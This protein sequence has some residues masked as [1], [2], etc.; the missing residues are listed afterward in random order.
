MAHK[1]HLALAFAGVAA[2]VLQGCGWHEPD[3]PCQFV[4]LGRY[5][6]D[7]RSELRIANDDLSDADAACCNSVREYF[8]QQQDGGPPPEHSIVESCGEAAD[9]LPSIQAM[10]EYIDPDNRTVEDCMVPVGWLGAECSSGQWSRG[11][12]LGQK[13]HFSHW[14]SM[15]SEPSDDIGEL[16]W[17]CLDDEAPASWS[18]LF[19]NAS[20][21]LGTLVETV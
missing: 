2:V 8:L 12:C 5:S 4:L 17:A 13:H 20:C 3:H 19:G 14:T 6:C 11:C 10:C 16:A 1:Q 7:A 15:I 9:Q 21:S 18:H